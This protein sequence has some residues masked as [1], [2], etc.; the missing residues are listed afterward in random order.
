MHTLLILKLIN[1][2][3]MI[4]IGKTTKKTSLHIPREYVLGVKVS[5]VPL[6]K[7]NFFII[8][9]EKK[10]PSIYINS[11]WYNFAVGSQSRKRF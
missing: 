3:C 8:Y 1:A 4:Q 2:T 5:A 7:L 6:R 11:A 9:E 10:D